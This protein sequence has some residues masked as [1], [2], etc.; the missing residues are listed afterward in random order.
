MEVVYLH[1]LA[2][3]RKQLRK[4]T[5]SASINYNNFLMVITRKSDYL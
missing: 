3:K 1:Q 4:H 5:L 2:Q